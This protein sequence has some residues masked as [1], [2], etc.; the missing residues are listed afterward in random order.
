[1]KTSHRN[2]ILK[3]KKTAEVAAVSQDDLGMAIAI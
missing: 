3:H 2:L 1:M